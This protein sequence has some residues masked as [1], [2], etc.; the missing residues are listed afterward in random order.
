MERYTRIIGGILLSLKNEFRYL[1]SQLELMKV[2]RE[3]LPPRFYLLFGKIV[4]LI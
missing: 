2:E 4:C 3:I 1:S